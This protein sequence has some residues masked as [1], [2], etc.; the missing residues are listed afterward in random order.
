[1]ASTSN[2]QPMGGQSETTDR[3]GPMGG[4]GGDHVTGLG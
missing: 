1:L 3:E 4:Q 2:L